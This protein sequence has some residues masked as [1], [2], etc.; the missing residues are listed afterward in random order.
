VEAVSAVPSALHGR[1][2]DRPNVETLVI[3]HK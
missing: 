3:T 1:R 2:F